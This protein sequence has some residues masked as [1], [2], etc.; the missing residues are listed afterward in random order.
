[1]GDV[2]DSILNPLDG[3][4]DY[5]TGRTDPPECRDD[6]DWGSY[7]SEEL[8]SV[9]VCLQSNDDGGDPR[10]EILLRSNRNTYQIVNEPKNAEFTWI[11]DELWFNDLVS[12]YLGATGSHV[13]LPGGKQVSFGFRQRSDEMD[14]QIRAL[15]SPQII[16]LNGVLAFVGGAESKDAVLALL[17]LSFNCL[18]DL[19]L[20]D[21]GIIDTTAELLE[22]AVSCVVNALASD[23]SEKLLEAAI[24]LIGIGDAARISSKAEGGLKLLRP[25][26]KGLAR[27]LGVGGA[28]VFAWDSIFDNIAEGRLDV[29]FDASDQ[30]AAVD[31]DAL[32]DSCSGD[33]L[34]R[35]LGSQVSI[36]GEACVGGW[37]VVDLCNEEPCGDSWA[38]VR[39]HDGNWV[40]VTGFPTSS[41]RSDFAAMGAPDTV[42]DAVSW[43]P[44][45][46][47]LTATTTTATTTT[48][49]TATSSKAAVYDAFVAA[50]N[51]QNWSA[52]TV[53]ADT[54]TVALAQ[55]SAVPG[56]AVVLGPCIS[57]NPGYD[58]CEIA[59]GIEGSTNLFVFR[60]SDRVTQLERS[61]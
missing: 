61:A 2:A 25:T 21:G 28:G 20:S 13:L 26:A 10:A 38:L 46:G 56:G 53:V 9:H 41:C 15:Q 50:W 54:A 30:V 48:T 44:G 22:T 42:L 45:C 40:R 36:I 59:Y 14:F 5:F 32:A 7:T 43:G 34:L 24:D 51:A 57:L 18:W 3:V 39:F 6:V 16:V 27:F 47:Q 35:D 4:F 29:H 19:G 37:A 17:I 12:P 1:M 23:D 58:T 33:V 11:E 52:M 60:L 31:A 8:S 49:T 55:G